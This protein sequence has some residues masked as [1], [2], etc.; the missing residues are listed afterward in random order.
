MRVKQ[1]VLL[2]NRSLMASG[3]QQLLQG[4][5]GLELSVVT[6]LDREA[7]PVLKKLAPDVILLDAGDASL[8]KSVIT[9]LLAEHPKARVIALNANRLGIE[10]YRL[11]RV[12]QAN[13]NGLLKAIQGRAAPSGQE[14]V[15]QRPQ[16]EGPRR[17]ENGGAAMGP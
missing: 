4:V 10:V 17:G 9:Q 6:A 16:R 1:V 2:S 5:D 3:L 11:K 15:P 14:P 7:V 13:L 8:G 12:Q